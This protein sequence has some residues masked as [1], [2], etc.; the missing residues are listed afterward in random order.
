MIKP[1]DFKLGML[2]RD[3]TL[4][5][6]MT[7][8]GIASFLVNKE[9]DQPTRFQ[10]LITNETTKEGNFTGGKWYDVVA[11]ARLEIAH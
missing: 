9:P 4:N 1:E 3:T 11:Q 10:V 2:V 8:V 6:K 5:K 7:V